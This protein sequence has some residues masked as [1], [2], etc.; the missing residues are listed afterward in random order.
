MRTIAQTDDMIRGALKT[1]LREAF[2]GVAPDAACWY[3]DAGPGGSLMDTL[4][5]LSADDASR[6]PAD[7]RKAIAAHV[8]HVSFHIEVLCAFLMGE[9]QEI[10]WEES[11]NVTAVTDEQWDKLRHDLYAA[12][13]R[14]ERVIERVHYKELTLGAGIGAIA[15]IAY[16]F[17][18]IRQIAIVFGAATPKHAQVHG[19]G[20][21]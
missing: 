15:H 17:G 4:S 13:V 6:P 9:R 7:G 11:W 14:F 19:T 16:H 2:N 20:E 8:A 1:L 3:I 5:T 21:H 18:A 10:N 12:Y